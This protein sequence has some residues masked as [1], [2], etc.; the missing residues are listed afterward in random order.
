MLDAL[1][2]A[3]DS[4]FEPGDGRH[5]PR[6]AV[7]VATVAFAM[8]MLELLLA[9]MFPFFLG[10]L[11]AFVAIPVTM[12]GLSLGALALHWSPRDADPRWLPLLVPLLLVMAFGTFLLFFGLFNEVFD[13]TQ[14]HRQN[15]RADALRTA[16]LSLLFV[17]TFAVAG[18]I[19]SMAFTAGARR[20]GQLYALDLG[21]SALACVLTPLALQAVDLPLVICVLLAALAGSTAVVLSGIRRPLILALGALLLVLT[22]L[23]AQQRVFTEHPDAATLAVN[24]VDDRDATEV[25]HRWNAISRTA[26]VAFTR[27]GQ[28]AGHR[29]IHDD[30]ISN[31]YVNAFD[32]QLVRKP[33]RTV[34][35]Q[36]LP[37]LLDSPPSTAMVMFAGCGKDMVKMQELAA[38]DIELTGVELNPLSR[39]LV[40]GRWDDWNLEAF[41]AQPHVDLHIDEGRSFLEHDDARYDLVYAAT[42]GA[43]HATR[44]GH[45][46]KY[47]DTAEAMEAYLDHLAEGGTIVFA[48]Q[49]VHFKIEIFKRL[50]AERSD[51]PFHDCVIV[52]GRRAYSKERHLRGST[53][54]VKPTGFSRGEIKRI[55]KLWRKEKKQRIYYTPLHAPQD[56]ID[57]YVRQ[58]VQ[59]EAF[60]PT[61]DQPFERRVDFAGFTLTP[62]AEQLDDLPFVMSWIKVF[63]L[64]LYGG[65]ALLT[66]A[67]FYMRGRGPVDAPARRLPAWLAGYFMLTGVAYMF[68][69]IGLM[70]KL[71]LFM[72]NPLYSIATVLAAYLMANGLGSAWVGRRTLAGRPVSPLVPA[73]GAALAVPLTLLVVDQGLLHLLGLPTAVKA[74]LAVI[75]LLPLGFC[76]GMFYPVGVSMTERRGLRQLVPKTFGLATLSS[77]LGATW[78]IV[79]VIDQGFRAVILQ[80]AVMYMVLAAVVG[81]ISWNRDRRRAA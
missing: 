54:L 70:A 25:R 34:T 73:A 28:P 11:N 29:I 37:F 77:M 42:N 50:L 21:G 15:P 19:L 76:L 33:R 67:A 41:Y 74:P 65:L 64:L 12:F 9:R 57:R 72:G 4:A 59:P 51:V 66:L 80:A 44:T 46:R 52:L 49:H 56:E 68:V 20:V 26:L 13:V 27:D 43:Q 69:Q 30:G 39:D 40:S 1:N 48:L 24:Y 7:V 35:P 45:A 78:A 16:T 62:T 18:V 36:S 63:T 10:D 38:G 32:P 14:H 22:G 60:V 5:Q 71:E 6:L 47:L 17:P 61:D 31:V 75:A 2:R 81:V 23:A 79:A 58:P 53:L 3:A 55:R 8:L